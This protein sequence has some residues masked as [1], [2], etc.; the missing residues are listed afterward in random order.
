[1]TCLEGKAR[2]NFEVYDQEKQS[3]LY[4]T[5]LEEDE[6][7][8]GNIRSLIIKITE[9]AKMVIEEEEK[10]KRRQA[11]K[12]ADEEAIKGDEDEYGEENGEL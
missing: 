8:V 7:E 9:K 12:E 10:A 3:L 4:R 6:H 2:R 11:Q 1:M 5:I